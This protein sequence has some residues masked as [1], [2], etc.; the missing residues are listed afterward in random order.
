MR[1]KGVFVVAAVGFSFFLSLCLA[2]VVLRVLEI[3]HPVFHRRD[4]LYGRTLIPGAEGWYTREGRAYVRI[5][6]LGFR[7]YRRELEK[8][9]KTCRIAILG[10]SCAEALQ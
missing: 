8:P 1:R 5:N 9:E 10:D 4:P 2:E 7:D 3:G 6:E